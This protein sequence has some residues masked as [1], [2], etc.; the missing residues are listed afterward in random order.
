M[1]KNFAVAA[2]FVCGS[3]CATMAEILF[4]AEPD[5]RVMVGIDGVVET[6]L[7]TAQRTENQVIIE[8]RD[9]QFF[10]STRGGVELVYRP[11]GLFDVFV[12]PSGAGYIK[13]ERG[14]LAG[15]PNRFLEH[16]HI[17]LGTVTYFG[18]TS[19]YRLEMLQ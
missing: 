5:R 3:A 2:F 8:M 11:S 1:V 13:V 10:W 9:G 7:T 12:A 4:H 16:V 17:H 6:I 14:P 15:G 18:S 19:A